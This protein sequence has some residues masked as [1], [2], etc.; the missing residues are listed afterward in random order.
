MSAPP[1]EVTIAEHLP[2][3][4][5]TLDYTDRLIAL[6]P[7]DMLDY[8]PENALGHFFFTPA[9]IAM[10]LAD[11]RSELAR[12]LG[13]SDSRDGFW[14]IA[15][16]ETGGDGTPWQFREY[17]DNA[18]LPAGLRESRAE[19][20]PWLSLPVSTLQESTDGTRV[21]YAKQLAELQSKGIDTATMERRGPPSINRVLFSLTTHE[22][23]HR[24]YLQ[25]ILRLQGID[26]RGEH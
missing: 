17:A 13:G 7:E 12:M 2:W 25:T 20:K 15:N 23:A 22:A 19:L 14:T 18:E 4:E 6:T 5:V 21:A 24:G 9:E 3:V 11:E 8:R 1:Q 26:A 10:H 16:W